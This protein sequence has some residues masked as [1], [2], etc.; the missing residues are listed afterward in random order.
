MKIA[1]LIPNLKCGGA[2]RVFVNLINEIS[3]SDEYTVDLLLMKYEGEYTNDIN[4]NVNIYDFNKKSMRNTVLNLRSYIRKN[5]PDI[6]LSA[7]THV[8]LI[9]CMLKLL[10]RSEMK[11]FCT[12]H[13]VVSNAFT[14]NKGIKADLM[15][16]A[17]KILY[18]LPDGIIAVS[19]SI[20]TDLAKKF[21][22]DKSKIS[23]IYNPIISNQLIEI[24]N[25]RIDH[26]WFNGDYGKI[27]LSVGRLNKAKDYSTLLKAFQIVNNKIRSKL[28]ILGSG[29][30]LESLL[31]LSEDL[32][33]TNEVAFL[34]YVENPYKYMKKADIFVLSSKYEGFG[35]VIVE[36]MAFNKK[37]VSTRTGGPVEILENGK[38]GTI[39][40]IGDYRKLAD[41]IINDLSNEDK[42]DFN[43]YIKQFQVNNIAND[44]IRL[45]T[46]K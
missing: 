23:K 12:E 34:G 20:R 42:C 13:T 8:N 41:A 16:I 45:I 1:F 36:A 32:G 37:I 31:T 35:N 21:A 44:Y 30:E 26:K 3:M 4:G 39:V 46:S 28:V 33:I 10:T 2:E 19:E 6:F 5:K 38:H 7:L 25:E 17:I 11:L 22:V 14:T 40:P 24:A 15:K 18:R 27:M 9:A 29:D 43:D